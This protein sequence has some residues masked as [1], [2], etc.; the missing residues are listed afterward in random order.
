MF[1]V[2]N[3]V[4]GQE[5]EGTGCNTGAYIWISG[6]SVI[7]FYIFIYIN[8]V[9]SQSPLLQTEETQLPQLFLIRDM[10]HSLNNF[11]EALK[12][13]STQLIK[14][15]YHYGCILKQTA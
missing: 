9:T 11:W 1:N 7:D 3:K 8:D 14:T 2:V 12:C 5:T 6:N 15:I 13:L 10:L 4:L